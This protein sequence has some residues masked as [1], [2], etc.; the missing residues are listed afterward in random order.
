MTKTM[1]VMPTYNEHENLPLIVQAIMELPAE[2]LNILVVDDNSPDGT[3]QLAEE[4]KLK[5]PGRLDVLHRQEKNGLGP[6]YI[7]G[8]KKAISLGADYLVQMD[9]DFSHQPKYLLD[10]IAKANEG[11]DM[12]A[13]SRFASGGSVDESWPFYRKLLSRF[14]NRVYVPLLLH[15]PLSDATGGFRLWRKQTLIGIDLDRVRSSGYVFQVEIAYLTSQLGYRIAEIPIYFPDRR[16]GDSKMDA[17]IQIEAAVRVWQVMYR[18]R[19]LNPNKR[20][21][22]LYTVAD[23]H[24]QHSV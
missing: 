23:A 8:F 11:Y 24:E 22:R 21:T 4:L 19:G 7:A 13:G 12:V 20:R 5:Y 3:G 2:D 16:L 14:A 15:L 6:A 18:H 17:R 10:L 1:V 9:A